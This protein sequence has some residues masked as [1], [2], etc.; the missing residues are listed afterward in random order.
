[1]AIG[2]YLPLSKVYGFEPIPAA[3]SE[4]EAAHVLGAQGNIWT[5]Y[6]STVSHMQYMALLRIA[7]LSEVT[8]NTKEA[9]NWTDFKSR[10]P[11]ANATMRWSTTIQTT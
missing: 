6:I 2:G 7:A 10:E 4:Q 11:S 8:W 3:L 9:R 5:E 1:M